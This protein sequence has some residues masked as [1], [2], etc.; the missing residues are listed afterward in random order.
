MFNETC[1]GVLGGIRREYH[2]EKKEY[3]T[4]LLGLLYNLCAEVGKIFDR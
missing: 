3:F 4:N 2:E 1:V